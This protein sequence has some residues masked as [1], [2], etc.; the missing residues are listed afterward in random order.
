M[1]PGHWPQAMLWCGL[2]A[3]AAWAFAASQSPTLVQVWLA[4]LSLCG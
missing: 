2:A 4:Q 1:S 3:V